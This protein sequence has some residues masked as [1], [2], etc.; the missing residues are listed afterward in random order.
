[1]KRGLPKGVSI[2]THACAP[3]PC[4]KGDTRRSQETYGRRLRHW[5]TR[6]HLRPDGMDGIVVRMTPHIAR[7]VPR[8]IAGPPWALAIASS[9]RFERRITKFG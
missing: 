6:R 4:R 5:D 7:E 3:A 2:P 1:V 9:E 8:Q